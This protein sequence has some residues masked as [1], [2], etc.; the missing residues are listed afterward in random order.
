MRS[1]EPER[2]IDGGR[3]A[4]FVCFYCTRPVKRLG[5]HFQAVLLDDGEEF[6]VHAAGLLG[7]GLPHIKWASGPLGF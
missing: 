2:L 5:E 4:H 6:E 1:Q 3:A 7:T